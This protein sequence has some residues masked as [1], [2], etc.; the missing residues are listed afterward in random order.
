MIKRSWTNFYVFYSSL[1][2]IQKKKR[3]WDCE[4]DVNLLQLCAI[5]LYTVHNSSFWCLAFLPKRGPSSVLCS[6]SLQNPDTPSSCCCRE[7][8]LFWELLASSFLAQADLFAVLVLFL[9][10][11]WLQISGDILA[12]WFTEWNKNTWPK[13]IY[14]SY[15]NSS[16]GKCLT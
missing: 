12:P 2:C 5:I 3:I 15:L 1:E 7:V 4:V 11:P 9:M 13:K 14:M 8:P 6:W 10:H 16:Y